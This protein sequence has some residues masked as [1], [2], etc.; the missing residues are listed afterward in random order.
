[1]FK[2]FKLLVMSMMFSAVAGAGCPNPCGDTQTENCLRSDGHLEITAAFAGV[3][4]DSDD[5]DGSLVV[6]NGA[7]WGCTLLK[8]V[9]MPEV[10]EIGSSAFFHCT[11]LKSVSMPNVQRIGNGAF[12][13][14]FLTWVYMPKVTTIGSGGYNPTDPFYNTPYS[15]KNPWQDKTALKVQY[16]SLGC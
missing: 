4:M 8:T 1:M 7:F 13:T 5:Q 11:T 12:M 6:G 10:T 15:T 9:S 3:T 16:S 2:L 14:T